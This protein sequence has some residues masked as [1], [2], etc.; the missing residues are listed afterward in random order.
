MGNGVEHHHRRCGWSG[1]SSWEACA[2]CVSPGLLRSAGVVFCL[3]GV[4]GGRN[5]ASANETFVQ[6][7]NCSLISGSHQS[8]FAFSK[9]A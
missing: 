4:S 8:T 5:D 3:P 6:C 2:F 1:P 9:P 7:S